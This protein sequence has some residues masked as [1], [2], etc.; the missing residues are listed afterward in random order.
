MSLKI[1]REDWMMEY[2]KLNERISDPVNENVKALENIF[3]SAVKDGEVDFDALKEEL[4][5]FKK[6]GKEK[7]ELTWAGKQNAKKKAQEPV[8]GRT[9]KYVPEESKDADTTQNLYIEGD[10][11]EVLKLLRENYYGSIKM[12]YDRPSIQYGK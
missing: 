1:C 3:P 6:A 12:I 11:L 7:Y 5:K 4:G 2:K 8:M 10:N 9:L